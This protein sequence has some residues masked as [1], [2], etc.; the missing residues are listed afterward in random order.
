MPKTIVK[1]TS[2]LHYKLAGLFV[3]KYPLM[4]TVMIERP[5]AAFV[6]D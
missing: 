4:T 6:D 1:M 5:Q 2:K 3:D